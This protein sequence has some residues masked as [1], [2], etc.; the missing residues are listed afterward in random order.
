MEKVDKK[1]IYMDNW[2]KKMFYTHAGV[3]AH[4]HRMEYLSDIKKNTIFPFVTT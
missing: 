2:I 3:H 4:A 1:T